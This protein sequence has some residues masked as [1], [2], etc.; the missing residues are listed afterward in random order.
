MQ[1]MKLTFANTKIRLR[2][3]AGSSTGAWTRRSTEAAPA[4]AATS[5][6]AWHEAGPQSTDETT[7]AIGAERDGLVDRDMDNLV[8]AAATKRRIKAAYC[9]RRKL[10]TY[11]RPARLRT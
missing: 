8:D 7:R 11:A 3:S 5:A 10:S 9:P 4:N 1:M 6:C 2:S